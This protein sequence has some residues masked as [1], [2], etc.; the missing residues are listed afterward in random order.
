M[1]ACVRQIT[2]LCAVSTQKKCL[3][4]IWALGGTGSRCL[5]LRNTAGIERQKEKQKRCDDDQEESASV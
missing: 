3:Y 5:S 4:L 1:P 2:T